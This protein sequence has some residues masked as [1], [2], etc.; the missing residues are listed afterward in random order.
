M[1]TQ[2]QICLKKHLSQINT[3]NTLSAWLYCIF[4][5][6]WERERETAS[7]MF[8]ADMGFSVSYCKM[9]TLTLQCSR[10]L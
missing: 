9:Q 3:I 5:I 10:W 6:V 7:D 1:T 2:E 4:L 8:D